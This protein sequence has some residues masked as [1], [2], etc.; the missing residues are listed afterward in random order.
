[1][2]CVNL[3]I[4]QLTFLIGIDQTRYKVCKILILAHFAPLSPSLSLQSLCIT[5]SI[6][7]QYMFL[8]TFMWM[9]MEGVVL[10]VTLVK[11]FI[12]HVKRYIIA[13]TTIS[14]GKLR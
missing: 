8:V 7:L 3:F 4:S 1:M 14:Y 10:Y 2:L 9:L 12:K 11:V 5:I 13:F 6:I